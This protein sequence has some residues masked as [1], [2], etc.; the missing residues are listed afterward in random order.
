VID[1]CQALYDQQIV[2]SFDWPGWQDEARRLY[3]DPAA[4]GTER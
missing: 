1:F 2:F 4:L 3:S